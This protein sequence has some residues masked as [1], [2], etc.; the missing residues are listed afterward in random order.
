MRFPCAGFLTALWLLSI[1]SLAMVVRAADDVVAEDPTPAPALQ[2][3]P[4]QWLRMMPPR[5]RIEMRQMPVEDAGGEA[6]RE[7]Y[8][9]LLTGEVDE[10]LR[11]QLELPEGVGLVVE[12]VTE[13]GPAEQAG[14]QRLDIL[15]KLDDQLICNSQ[16]LSALVK[17]T[18]AGKEV[19][20]TVFRAG[21]KQQLD[22]LIDEREVAGGNPAAAGRFAQRPGLLL[23]RGGLD[24]PGLDLQGLLGEA[25]PEGLPGFDG[26]LRAQI[27]KQVREA[28][29]QAEAGGLGGNA[30]AQVF[31]FAPGENSQSVVVADGRG[32]VEIRETDGKRTVTI[33]DPFGEEVHAG[34]LNTDADRGEIPEPFR[35]MVGEVEGGLLGDRPPPQETPT[36]KPLEDDEI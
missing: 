15:Q 10:Q 4:R 18:G 9:G 8:L 17:V 26:D 2:L 5:V 33:K 1:L 29:R 28:I 36:D 27:Q 16:Q 35:E 12:A 23:E 34:P 19:R 24:A 20:L 25:F 7:P 6:H 13:D 3:A 11:A 32:S 31:E 14:V 22:V 30:R 21:K